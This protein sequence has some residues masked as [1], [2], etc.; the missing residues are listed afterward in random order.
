MQVQLN[1]DLGP[2]T[3]SQSVPLYDFLSR[4]IF[5][6]SVAALFNQ[7]AG[8]DRALFDAFEKFDKHL[9]MAAG[10]YKV[11]DRRSFTKRM[12]Y[13]LKI[14]IILMIRYHTPVSPTKLDKSYWTL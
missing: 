8:D 9:P 6:A 4:V 2:R 13:R 3:S 7:A 11:R 1:K 12:F 10:G 14:Y 5:Q